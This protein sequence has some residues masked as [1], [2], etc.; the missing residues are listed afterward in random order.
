[1]CYECKTAK[2]RLDVEKSEKRMIIGDNC[3]YLSCDLPS[4]L[5]ITRSKEVRHHSIMN[6]FVL[7]IVSAV[8]FLVLIMIHGPYSMF[9]N[10]DVVDQICK[11]LMT[12]LIILGFGLGILVLLISAFQKLFIAPRIRFSRT[13][14]EIIFQKSM[15][16]WKRTKIVQFEDI[17]EVI[18][19]K[20]VRHVR[21]V[22]PSWIFWHLEVE[23]KNNKKFHIVSG[24]EP[25]YP[26]IEYWYRAINRIVHNEVL[27]E[28]H[29]RGWVPDP[30]DGF[31][32]KKLYPFFQTPND[33][34]SEA[35]IAQLNEDYLISVI[36]PNR[37]SKIIGI[38]LLTSLPILPFLVFSVIGSYLLF[39]EDP[40]SEI[41]SIF[42]WAFFG[43][44]ALFVYP[45]L[46]DGFTYSGKVEID[47][48]A[49]MIDYSGGGLLS[50]H[51]ANYSFAEIA[52]VDHQFRRNQTAR[53]WDVRIKL[54]TNESIPIVM[55]K[56]RK[57]KA[58]NT[59]LAER[60]QK[61]LCN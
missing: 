34:F 31:N 33:C 44:A 10:E 30:Y 23:A 29:Y 32:I 36:R 21:D 18:L 22:H 16:G 28:D 45:I 35:K 14:N 39:P 47:F 41:I 60:L 19:R 2:T 3:L 51:A 59:K 6:F 11:W 43:V 7:V 5:V 54:K 1:M 12:G 40:N 15:F 37:S 8:C 38:F 13:G 52:D 26:E 27:A 50:S 56:N 25:E 46:L 61:L 9:E 42:F 24:G 55:T 48:A 49:K 57:Q 4:K 17:Q 53:S 58:E 20:E